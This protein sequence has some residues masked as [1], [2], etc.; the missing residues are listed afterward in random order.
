MRDMSDEQV[1][2]EQGMMKTNGG[3]N[4]QQWQ[5]WGQQ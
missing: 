5:Q 2:N 4:G 1:M 3:W